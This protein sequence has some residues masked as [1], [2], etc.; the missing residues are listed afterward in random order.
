MLEFLDKNQKMV[1]SAERQAML[2]NDIFPESKHGKKDYTVD[3]FI[4]NNNFNGTSLPQYSL[5]C[6]SHLARIKEISQGAFFVAD[7][8]GGKP[9]I[10]FVS[11]YASKDPE[12][13]ENILEIGKGLPGQVARD[14]K[15]I[16]ITNIPE[17]YLI[18]ESGLGKAS[19]LSLLIFPVKHNDSVIAVIELSS[20]HKFT[21]EDEQFFKAISPSIAEQIAKCRSIS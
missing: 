1:I 8:K 9:V 4:R 20:F 19:P 14:G 18:I 11:G 3:Q 16:N 2:C 10:R 15:L 5:K 6:L 7:E 21:E 13:L 17:G 12:G